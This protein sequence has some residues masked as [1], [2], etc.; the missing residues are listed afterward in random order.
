MASEHATTTEHVEAAK[1]S[2]EDRYP[3]SA[4]LWNPVVEAHPL[5]LL[6]TGWQVQLIPVC[7]PPP[8]L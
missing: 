6:P 5:F 7:R 1:F 4:L 3:R 2:L 8:P